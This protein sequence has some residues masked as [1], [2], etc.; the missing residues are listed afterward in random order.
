MKIAVNK[1]ELLSIMTKHFGIDIT[2]V[3]ITKG[4]TYHVSIMEIMS[5]ILGLTV[6]SSRM[7]S[8]E[9]KISA[10]KALREAVPGT[11]LAEAKWAIEN[12]NTWI[13]FVAKTGRIPKI[14]GDMWNSPKL[15]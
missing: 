8:P 5:K 13:S 6:S 14:E 11:E 7:F 9:M 10:I 1:S 15:V 3:T 4:F 12:W 2:E